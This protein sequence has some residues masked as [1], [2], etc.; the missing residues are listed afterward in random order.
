MQIKQPRSACSFLRE[1][2]GV[3]A[4]LATALIGAAL[5]AQACRMLLIEDIGDA[6]Q[7]PCALLEL[8]GQ[9]A[10]SAFDG[11]SGL[12]M[13]LEGTYDVSSATSAGPGGW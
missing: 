5:T 10:N 12:D 1:R 6:N 3:I 13:V 8:A 7:S 11:I 2:S 9:M 4:S